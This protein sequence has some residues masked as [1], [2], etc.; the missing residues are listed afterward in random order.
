[1]LT[2]L[3]PQSSDSFSFDVT[4]GI[5][6]LQDL[7]FHF[8]ILPK[9]LYIDTREL[10]VTEGGNVNLAANNIRVSEGQ[11]PCRSACLLSGILVGRWLI[12]A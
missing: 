3:N 7:V 12:F 6:G 5:S 1:M 11:E 8:R 2:F 10:V 9:T 4:N